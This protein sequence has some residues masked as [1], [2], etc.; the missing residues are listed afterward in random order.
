MTNSQISL[1]DLISIK[2]SLV[3]QPIMDTNGAYSSEFITAVSKELARVENE[4]VKLSEGKDPRIP[5]IDYKIK[6]LEDQKNRI[7]KEKS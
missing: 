3:I 7:S 6:L 4:I 1:S 5:E 2:N